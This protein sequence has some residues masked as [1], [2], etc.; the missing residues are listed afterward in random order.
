M[1]T[2]RPEEDGHAESAAPDRE[3]GSRRELCRPTL[4]IRIKPFT[5]EL[6]R[7][8]IRTLDLYLSALVRDTAGG[9]R[10]T[11]RHASEGDVPS[12]GGARAL[13]ELLERHLGLPE[14]GDPVRD[15]GGDPRPSRPRRSGSAARL[16]AAGRGRCIAA[17]SA[18][19]TTPRPELT[20]AYQQMTH[21]VCDFAKSVMQ[22]ALSG[23][24]HLDFGRA[25]NVLPVPPAS[26][27]GRRLTGVKSRR[28][29]LPSTRPEA[30]L[31]SRAHSSRTA[32]IRGGTSTPPAPH[33][34]RRAWGVRV[35]P[36]GTRRGPRAS[37]LVEK[38]GRRRSSAKFSTT[39]RPARPAE[40]LPSRV[41]LR[42]A[43]RGG[44]R[45]EE[46]LDS[47]RAA[48]PLLR[49]DPEEPQGVRSS[50][51]ARRLTWRQRS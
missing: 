16:V 7:R 33:P 38:G 27:G 45:R 10:R 39:P 4:G 11:F 31:R 21:P 51:K 25:T 35:F 13:R 6:K 49:E 2:A 23:H 47:G 46:R 19:T 43:H 3:R 15:H 36:R 1:E 5:E 50:R 22:V 40:P 24:G 28:T 14:T 48:R 29:A 37:E 34:L 26:R 30:P 44:S 17:H 42:R 18:H 32:S 12:R 41:E 9:S 20:A 8:A